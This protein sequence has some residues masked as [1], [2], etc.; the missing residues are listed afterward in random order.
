M[1]KRI[2]LI[3]FGLVIGAASTAVL[4]EDDNP[5]GDAANG[6]KLYE[7]VGCYQCHGYAAQGGAAGSKLNPPPAFPAFVLQLRTPR[8]IMPP[9][10]AA[11]LSDNQAADIQAYLMTMPKP[12]DPKTIKLLQ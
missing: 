11:V 6:K 2:W 12:P 10:A 3:L 9:Y 5:K 1:S 7:S 8:Q 4:A